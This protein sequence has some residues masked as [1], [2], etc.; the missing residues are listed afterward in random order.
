MRLEG[1]CYCGAVRYLAEGAPLLKVQ[2]HCRECQYFTGGHPYVAI[3]MSE[4][5]FGYTKGSPQA[6]ERRDRCDAVTREF[7]PVCATHILGRSPKL[8][9]CVS[10]KVGTLDDP[11]L[12]DRPEIVI[13]TIE[14]Q[15]FHHVPEGVPSFERAPM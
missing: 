7:C 9:G 8:P 14:K 11:A 1:G 12:F 5:G 15:S 10:I 2:C 3:A 6:F 4:D 13:F